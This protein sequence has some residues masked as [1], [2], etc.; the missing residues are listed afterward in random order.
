[1]LDSLDAGPLQCILDFLLFHDPIVDPYFTGM[2]GGRRDLVFWYDGS[3]YKA[4]T[5][6]PRN[7]FGRC[8]DQSCGCCR[9][10]YAK[11]AHH[12][13]QECYTAWTLTAVSKSYRKATN[14]NAWRTS[15]CKCG[16]CEASWIK[17]GWDCP[18]RCGTEWRDVIENNDL[19][20]TLSR[21]SPSPRPG[22]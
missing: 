10:N 21:T 16:G 1:M 11:D 22:A 17:S 5:W 8:P 13:C 18:V 19:G 15:S 14:L 9:A 7:H 20:I 3:R 12:G 6:R 4:R 2:H